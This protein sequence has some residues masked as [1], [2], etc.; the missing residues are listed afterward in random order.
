[1]EKVVFSL[2]C[3]LLFFQRSQMAKVE[4]R[5]C[6]KNPRPSRF[7]QVGWSAQTAKQS[8]NQGAGII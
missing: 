2:R 4:L 8:K 6:F 5:G 3:L 1:M 7:S